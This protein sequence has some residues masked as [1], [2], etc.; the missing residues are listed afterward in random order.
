MAYRDQEHLQH[1]GRK[2][3]RSLL[4]VFAI[5]SGLL[6][7][8]GGSTTTAQDEPAKTGGGAF[9]KTSD[10][11]YMT[12]DGREVLLDIYAPAGAGPWPVVVAFHG[13]GAKTDQTTSRVASEAAA[14]GML[15]FAPTWIDEHAFPHH[16]EHPRAAQAG[17]QLRGRIRA[18]AGGRAWGRPV[19]HGP[20]G[21]SAGFGPALWAA[22]SPR[23][24]PSQDVRLTNHRPAPMGSWPVTESI[25]CTPRPSM[26]HSMRILTPCRRR[27]RHSSIHRYWPS[28]LDAKFFLW[29]AAEGTN[30]RTVGDATDEIEL[31][32]TARPD[33]VDTS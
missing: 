29:T 20:Y 19:E 12:I 4:V 9:S 3:M 1:G 15:V 22:L 30:P 8:V 5:T 14:Q 7:G 24:V 25:S 17:G 32:H 28:D 10:V 2:G 18:G 23:R 27:R 11:A 26:V 16:G 31:A 33:R 6:V 13:L 21:F